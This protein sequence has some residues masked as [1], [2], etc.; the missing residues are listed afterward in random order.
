MLAVAVDLPLRQNFF[1]NFKKW[2]KGIDKIESRVLNIEWGEVGKRGAK[3]QA[4]MKD[5]GNERLCGFRGNP[6]GALAELSGTGI[7]FY[8]LNRT[9]R[10]LGELA[11][12]VAPL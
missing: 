12:R 9:Q 2:A 7:T 1:E 10:E 3:E 6:N 5:V 11:G 8:F 4:M